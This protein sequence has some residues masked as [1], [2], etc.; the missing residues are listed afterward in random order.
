MSAL[1]LPALVGVTGLGVE[2]GRGLMT[3]V[4]NQ[5]VADLGAYD[6]AIAYSATA[7]ATTLNSTVSRIAAL[8]GVASSA[9]TAAVVNSPG[10]N[11]RQ[12]VQVTVTTSLPMVLSTFLGASSTQQ[13]SATAFVELVPGTTP[14]CIIALNTNGNGVT[15]SGGTTVSAPGCAV[16]SNTSVTVPT[17]TSMTTPL[18]S[19]N[20]NVDGATAPTTDA[21]IHPPSGKSSVTY[22]KAVTPDPLS[23]NSAVSAAT[24]HLT[25]VASQTSPA[26][27]S[28]ASGTDLVF[29]SRTTTISASGCSGQLLNSIWTFTCP[30]G[31]GPYNFGNLTIGGGLTLNFNVGGSASNTYSFS[32][33]I[34]NSG[35]STMNF[36]PGTY[37]VVG[38]ISTGGGTNTAFGAGTFKLGF[39]GNSCNSG[40]YS[41][42][43]SGTTLSF[44]GPST[45]VLSSGIFVAGGGTATMGSGTTNS[46]QIG[47]SSTGNAVWLGGGAVLT[48][49]DATGGGSVFKTV[50][51][52]NVSSGGGSCLTLPAA[53]AHD[54]NGSFTSAG[55]SIFGAG[56]YSVNGYFALGDGGGGSVSCGGSQVGLSGSGV[57]LVIS[58][59]TTPSGSCVGQAFCVAGGFNNVTLTAPTSGSTNSLVVIGPSLSSRIGG[60]TFV[61][62]ASNTSLSGVVYFP[63]GP[64]SLSGGAHLGNG[65]GQC[66]EL[67]GTQVSLTGGSTAATTCTGVVGTVTSSLTPT[68]VLVK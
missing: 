19:F 28:V 20:T 1:L 57:T 68:F 9:A 11:G 35:G 26:A 66:L 38:G 30:A 22:T 61:E 31:G 15:L 5:R 63:N 64:V 27:P 3:K 43:H 24:S 39:S 47:A 55:G 56:I 6:G 8:N 41:I 29:G 25:A 62:G 18:V 40:T 50:G 52:L 21:N 34:T 2:Y 7:S 42:C 13:V 14:A 53:S 33:Q 51:T 45:F 58:G 46:Y 4:E 59:A 49:A 16:A 44:G 67:I 54:M 32:G 65:T 60:A 23:G 10:G 37:S 48:M 36:G 12:A 17:G